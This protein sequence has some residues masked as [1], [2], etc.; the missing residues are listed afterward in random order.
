MRRISRFFLI[1][2]PLIVAC[3]LLAGCSPAATATEEESALSEETEEPVVPS[4]TPVQPNATPTT[5]SPTEVP[6]G[7][8]A[9]PPEPQVIEFTASDGQ[10]LQGTYYPAAVNPAPVIVL[11]H[12]VNYDETDWD[13]IAVWLQNRGMPS[14]TTEPNFPWQDG[15]WFPA[16]PKDFSIGVF[17]FSFRDCEAPLGCR[18]MQP[19]AWLLDAQ[20][21]MQTAAG[22]EGVD[23]ANVI[24]AGASIGADGA[25]DG[26]VWLNEQVPNSCQGAFSLSPGSYL[27]MDYSET[28]FRMQQPAVGLE[29]LPTWC[30]ADEAE[31]GICNAAAKPNFTAYEMLEFPGA[32]HG[33]MILSPEVEPSGMQALLD[34]IEAAAGIPVP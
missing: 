28:V 11:M 26:C 29:A 18:S 6:S 25:I 30:L 2:V 22:L 27:G 7:P 23:P 15:S 20:A 21:A 5:A 17:T 10:A 34:F 8:A 1:L 13:A 24:S 31:I 3:S 9:L 16:T 12:W 32:G 4:E 14:R 33:M 19:Q